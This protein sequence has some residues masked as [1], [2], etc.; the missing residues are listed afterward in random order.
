M[1]RSKN[2]DATEEIIAF[3]F[4]VFSSLPLITLYHI[5]PLKINDFTW[6]DVLTSVTFTSFEDRWRVKA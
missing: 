4:F 6:D 2:I 1:I 3:L 5:H